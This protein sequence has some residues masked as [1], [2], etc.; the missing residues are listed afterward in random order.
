M[1]KLSWAVL[2]E[3]WIPG[4]LLLSIAPRAVS[5]EEGAEPKAVAQDEHVPW[6]R[7]RCECGGEKNK[8]FER[9][10]SKVLAEDS[11]FMGVKSKQKYLS[12]RNIW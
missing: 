10:T 3:E 12:I 1:V 11:I 5:W 4:I 8:Q 9:Q 6:W 2:W 7:Q